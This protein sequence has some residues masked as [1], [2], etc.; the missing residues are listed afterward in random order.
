MLIG[1]IAAEAGA[2]VWSLDNDFIR[3]ERAGLVE[4]Y[5]PTMR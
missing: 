5:D 2:L 4:L 1:A 3:M